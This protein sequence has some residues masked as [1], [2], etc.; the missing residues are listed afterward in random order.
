MIGRNALMVIILTLSSWIIIAEAFDFPCSRDQ[1]NCSRRL[2]F[3]ELST[4][5][6]HMILT[7]T[8]LAQHSSKF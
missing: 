1:K 3:L 6:D 8:M 7:W 2:S 4:I 5:S